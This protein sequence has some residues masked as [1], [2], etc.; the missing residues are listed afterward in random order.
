VLSW[1]SQPG[2][3]YIVQYRQTLDVS[4]PWTTLNNNLPA[5]SGS[6]RTTYTHANVIL[7]CAPGGQSAL[8]QPSPNWST[9]TE[10]ERAARFAERRKRAEAM[11]KEQMTLLKAAIEEARAKRERWA[12]E[13]RP[14]SQNGATG[15]SGT[16]SSQGSPDTGFYRV[17]RHGVH[18]FGITNG[19]VFSG[20]VSLPVEIGLPNMNDVPMEVALAAVAE[21]DDDTRPSGVE[22]YV[23][24]ETNVTPALRW[25][26]HRTTNGIYV[27]QAAMTLEG[28]AVVNGA[29]VTVAVSNQ[30]QMPKIP[31]V[32]VS[33]L[34]IYAI[35]DQPSANYTITIR[36]HE[37]QVVRTLTGQT[38][39]SVIN[40]FWDGL[41]GF[42]NNALVN[43]RHLDVTVS[44]NPSYMFRIWVLFE[45]DYVNGKWLIAYQKGIYSAVTEL[46]MDNAMQQ[47]STITADEGQVISPY[48]QIRSGPANWVS[49]TNLLFNQDTR[50]FYFWGHGSASVLGFGVN[51][52]NN[53]VRAR[54]LQELLGNVLVAHEIQIWQA[55]RFVWLDGC[56]TGVQGSAWPQTF[57]IQPVQLDAQDFQTVGGATRAFL[58]WKS[59]VATASV[60]TSRFTFAE[61]FFFNWISSDQNLRNAL[62]DAVTGAVDANEL[63]KLQIWGDPFLPKQGAFQ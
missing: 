29:S 49:L 53:G 22:L 50:N 19:Q 44:Y 45:D 42:G 7:E 38:V 9:L 32:I 54:A 6:D 2:E 5:A 13:G 52:P 34:P 10:K 63:K 15:E 55:F 23:L 57:G 51:D 20:I 28:G 40:D 48:L 59:Y 46:L 14:L 60:D 4:T 21:Q 58:G 35:I 31:V 25:D 61:N 27:L 62:D 24:N 16:A 12:K 36:N 1:P 17:V 3:T 56:T 11:L 43:H 8:S 39:N 18:L 37:G 30:I 26:T 41:D 47:I 33:G